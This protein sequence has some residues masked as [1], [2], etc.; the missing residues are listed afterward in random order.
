MAT[1][2]EYMDYLDDQIGISP[3]NSQEELQAAETIA[4]LM[5]NH[6]VDTKIE[7]FDANSFARLTPSILF[8]LMFV[9]ILFSGIDAGALP[10][11]GMLLAFVPAVL[12]V[13]NHLG[14]GGSFLSNLGPTVRSQNVVAFHKGTGDLVT[15]G[16]RPIVIVAH[17]DAP[18]ESFIYGSTLGAYLPKVRKYFSAIVLIVG[19]CG[20]LQVLT[21]LPTPFRKVMWIVGIICAIPIL[22]EGIDVI[23]QRFSPC[24]LGANDNKSG[25]A[26]M[27]GILENVHPTEEHLVSGR[28]REREHAMRDAS[29]VAAAAAATPVAPSE[30]ESVAP[31]VASQPEPDEG[32]TPETEGDADQ[33]VV[34][35]AEPTTQIPLAD[36]PEPVVGVRHGEEMIRQMGILPANC[37][38]SYVEHN[39][40]VWGETYVPPSAAVQPVQ[41]PIPA[42]VAP[43]ATVDA[44][45]MDDDFDDIDDI[46]PEESES[47]K[48]N[49]LRLPKIS[50][51]I[52][53]KKVSTGEASGG[54]PA[55]IEQQS[56]EAPAKTSSPSLKDRLTSLFH[57]DA[58]GEEPSPEATVAAPPA[59]DSTPRID[60]SDVN[61]GAP[62]VPTAT[63]SQNVE[64]NVA[65]N[66]NV[67]DRGPTDE[68]TAPEPVAFAPSQTLND[69]PTISSTPAHTAEPADPQ[70]TVVT[71]FRFA[72]DSND[73]GSVGER[74][75]SGMDNLDGVYDAAD[76]QSLPADPVPSPAAPDD[77][78]WG[79]S[80]YRPEISSVA[81]RAALYDLPDP[82]KS[83]DP[84]GTDP[85]AT[86][87][88]VERPTTPTARQ[89]GVQ[90]TPL[91][92]SRYPRNT[93]APNRASNAP[94]SPSQDGLDVITPDD[95]KSESRKRR[96][97]PK[98]G[99]GSSWKGGAA[100]RGDLRLVDDDPKGV[101]QQAPQTPEDA[102][103]QLDEPMDAQAA[104]S[105]P[106][107]TSNDV[108]TEDEL[109]NEVLNMGY[110]ELISHDIWFVALGSSELG[111]A[112]MK[113][114]LTEHR[115]DIRGAFLVNLECVG[116]GE[117]SLLTREGAEFPRRIDRR[118]ARL[119]TKTSSDLH[120]DLGSTPYDW[121]DTDATLA[122]RSSVRSATIMGLGDDGLPALSH[123]S[124]DVWENVDAEQI[125]R[126]AQLVTEI[127][128]RS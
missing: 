86:R 122:M 62:V 101:Q 44:P 51:L 4:E 45:P 78:T 90:S 98:N 15:K 77:P 34:S 66:A 50:N 59:S 61:M 103:N 29:A 40:E 112:G 60:V 108:P 56:N 124:N 6:N 73:L 37:E 43:V 100:P 97:S 58:K 89:R 81:R 115:R 1:T 33:T 3:A 75:T 94:A 125:E 96:R 67:G 95:I 25:V 88:S 47:E 9:G 76:T 127:I 65:T 11:I 5:R 102:I 70:A 117:L 68:A 72:E 80:S 123:K 36:K 57:R 121:I 55:D 38:I 71:R 128:R 63:V 111:N 10:I 24:T 104:T 31:E 49:T 93:A 41:A 92:N 20:L 42:T 18:H 21:F 74:D 26:A 39:C 54:E 8:I 82:S 118:I 23:Y 52:P 91:V 87:I 109:R 28:S 7:E 110:D 113:A 22:L 30:P 126:V 85:N 12:F 69:V 32:E 46:E 120:I 83:S 13:L 19:I 2:Q 27:M 105:Q 116:A 84:F 107:G 53:R 106:N 99:G 14:I 64:T 17:Y 35:A 79:Q 119:L 48:T 114:F 16:K